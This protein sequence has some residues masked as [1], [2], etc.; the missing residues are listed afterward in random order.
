MTSRLR[1][2]DAEVRALEDR[3]R[4]GGGAKK[5]AKLHEQG[6]LS[7]RERI[8]LLCDTGTHFVEIGLFAAAEDGGAGAPLYLH[9]HRIRSGEQSIPVTVA[10]KPAWAGIDPRNLLIDVDAADN[11]REITVPGS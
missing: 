1:T 2:L 6:K 9:M 11:F 8:A 4:T 10:R 3:L 7:A 5:L